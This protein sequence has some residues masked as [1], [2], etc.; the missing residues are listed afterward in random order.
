MPHGAVL[1]AC[2]PDEFSVKGFQLGSNIAQPCAVQVNAKISDH[3]ASVTSASATIEIGNFP[4]LITLNEFQIVDA[5]QHVVSA[6]CAVLVARRPDQ[7]AAILVELYSD[8][9]QPYAAQ[10][11]GEGLPGNVGITT[12]TTIQVINQIHL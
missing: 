1:V 12:I 5:R 10:I 8:V 6:D 4:N 11:N 2:R 3:I 7:A 9:A